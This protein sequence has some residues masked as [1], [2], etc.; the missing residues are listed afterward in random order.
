MDPPIDQPGYDIVG[1]I[2]GSAAALEHL[3]HQLGYRASDRSLRHKT[4]QAV[5]VGDLIDRG[6]DQI[7]VLSIV[8][9]M[10]ATGA[11]YAVMGNHEFN[12]M[13]YFTPHPS[14]PH[15]HLRQHTPKHIAQHNEFLKQIGNGSADHADVV[16][17]FATLPLWLDLVDLRVVHAC[18]DGSAMAGLASAVVSPDVLVAASTRG[19]DAYRWVEHLCKGP[20]VRLPDGFD[21]LDKDGNRR[22]E[23]RFRWW[24]SRPAN[25]MYSCETPG[26]V[27][28]PDLAIE[29]VPVMPYADALPVFFGHYWRTWPNI[30]ATSHTACVDYSAVR[31]GPLVAYRW[32]GERT[33]D[34][35]HF[36]AAHA[37]SHVVGPYVA[38]PV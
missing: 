15:E 5:F 19:S 33:I 18:W 27:D 20:E 9:D 6:P 4:R 11:A 3:L 14:R 2:H 37:A 1:D 22:V 25:F 17:W 7:R 10:I 29:A 30:D 23:A 24:E 26:D 28:L 31:G 12:A 36:V 35:S 32:S 13:A 38:E 8:R 16:A 21:F 34:P